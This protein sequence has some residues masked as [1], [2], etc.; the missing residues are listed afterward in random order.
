MFEPRDYQLRAKIAVLQ[1]WKDGTNRCLVSMPTGTGKT[2]MFGTLIDHIQQKAG[3][4]R[5]LVLAHREELI[6]QAV[7]KLQQISPEMD[8]GVVK[9]ER[10]EWEKPVVVASVQSLH[11]K[12]R[13]TI[14]D[15]FDIIVID[16]AHHAQEDNSYGKI[17]A[18]SE[19]ACADL[20]RRCRTVGV[21][22]TPFR[23]DGK[24]LGEVFQSVGFTYSIPDAVEDGW[25]CP[26][27]AYQIKTHV[28]L[29]GC[30]VNAGD[31]NLKQLTQVVNT[32]NNNGLV[33]KA[34]LKHC[35]GMKALAFCVDVAHAQNLAETMNEYGIKTRAVWGSMPKDERADALSQLANGEI[36][37]VTNCMVLSEGFDMPDLG[38]VLLCRP[39]L[40]VVVYQQQVGRVTRL[41][42]GKEKGIVLDFTYNTKRLR[43]ASLADLRFPGVDAGDGP[44]S[45]PGEGAPTTVFV[46]IKPRGQG[47]RSFKVELFSAEKDGVAW[48]EHQA[49]GKSRRFAS[50]GKLAAVI[51]GTGDKS[52][53]YLVPTNK[54]QWMDVE[55]E[56]GSFTDLVKSAEKRLREVGAMEIAQ[57]TAPWK[58]RKPSNKQTK[59]CK[60]WKVAVPQGAT[61]GEVAALLG[62]KMAT[63]TISKWQHSKHQWKK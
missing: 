30:K 20:G 55:R 9:A 19:K 52:V 1:S 40:S 5:C 38:A 36:D 23:G 58:A 37:V 48:T 27:G 15:P 29:D 35:K 57:A 22:A 44:G 53:L 13:E 31:F 45:P 50:A 43:M 51:Q 25:L 56:I 49:K 8:I 26:I 14:T 32:S 4:L 12:R 47:L 42:E 10:N 11:T 21:T 3:H 16:E 6:N 63:A 28:S 62:F 18:W 41:A 60:S 46:E 33:A 34:Y 2:V 54:K 61:A 39:T 7:D 24:G 17:L 59:A